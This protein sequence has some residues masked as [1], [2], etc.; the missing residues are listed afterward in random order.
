[1][2]EMGIARSVGRDGVNRPADVRVVQRLLLARGFA[3]VGDADGLCGRSTLAAISDFQSGF[4]RRPDGL[5]EPDGISWRHL[6]G[7]APGTVA[8]PP[9]TAPQTM[10]GLRALTSPEPRPALTTLN[11]ELKAVNNGFMLTE[12]GDPRGGNYSSQC[13]PPTHPRLRRNLVLDT[14][15]PFRVTGLLPAVLS[16]K[17]V[18]RDI[19][20][21]QPD[22]YAALGTAGM[23]CCRWARGSSQSISNHAW[24]TALDVTINGVLDVYGDGRVQYGL[25]LIAPIFNRHGWFWGAAFRTED[26]MHFEASEALVRSWLPQLRA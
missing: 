8:P 7:A 24:G 18:M 17:A 5:I 13:Q 21:E 9:A 25:T 19:Q 3:R 14:V 16:L 23:L 10:A 22:V 2:A 11:P 12:L 1:M 4:L 26:G 20:A 15:G 6:S